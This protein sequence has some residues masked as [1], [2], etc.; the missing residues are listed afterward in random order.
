MTAIQPVE[1]KTVLFYDD[2]ITA[3]RLE[4]GQ[5]LI[6]IRPICDLMGLSWS[7]QADRI[8]RDLVLSEIVATVRV[9]RTE[10]SREV[11]REFVTSVNATKFWLKRFG[12]AV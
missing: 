8:E 9:T 11:N 1:Q 7:G 10:G 2:E 12:T 6:P 4:D 3:V 5:V